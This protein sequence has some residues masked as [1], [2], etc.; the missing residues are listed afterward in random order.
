M[1]PEVNLS[2]E[3]VRSGDLGYLWVNID[4]GSVRVGKARVKKLADKTIIKSINIFPEY[5]RR[6]FARQAVDRLKGSS[7][8]LVADRVRS[9]AR[10]F[11][12]RM[13]FVDA[14]DGNY[15]WRAAGMSYRANWA[16]RGEHVVDQAGL[17]Y[18]DG[19]G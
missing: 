18:A 4:N 16:G 7:R 17:A 19:D 1:A 12:E 3:Q 11:W 6:G 8:Q 10:G 2:F 13:G 5:E 15:T 14:G 9:S